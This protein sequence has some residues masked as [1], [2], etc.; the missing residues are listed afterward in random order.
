MNLSE[1]SALLELSIPEP[2]KR[3]IGFLEIT[4]Q[5]HKENVNSRVYAYFLDKALHTEIADVFIAALL[6]LVNKK[7]N[8]TLVIEDFTC[9]TEVTT[10]KGN[11]IDLLICDQ[12]N[13]TA[14]II[15]N[16]IY[17]YL[18]N[19]LRDYWTHI[20]Y[21]DDNKQGVL[22]TLQQH[23]IPDSE[24]GTF[25]NITHKEW[26]DEIKRIGLP[27]NV[28]IKKHVY[29]SDF[30]TTIIQ[31]TKDDKMNDQA[32][33]FFDHT[34]QIIKAQSTYTEAYNFV[35]GQFYK[36]AT[37]VG[38][39][40]CGKSDFWRYICDDKQEAYYSIVFG[41]LLLGKSEV[42]VIIELYE[43]A[44]TKTGILDEV[45][46][47]NPIVEKLEKGTA[48]NSYYK[49]YL[50]KKYQLNFKDIEK[51]GDFLYQKIQ[52]DFKP[53]MDIILKTL[54]E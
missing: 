35:I 43:G 1:F 15:E 50:L 26:I 10:K 49:H 47:G 46:M 27:T 32:R 42:I 36:L 24:K 33:F 30:M 17:H 40:L 48:G 18:N 31:L 7:R 11:R 6:N 16:K 12:T 29:L 38:W 20:E 2:V 44:I 39:K 28:E 53:V 52:E 45:L 19:D 8:T 21:K 13:E 4:Q 23:D 9:I 25:I 34:E 37:N 3:E 14:I 22:L 5:D 41:D 51:M 54:D